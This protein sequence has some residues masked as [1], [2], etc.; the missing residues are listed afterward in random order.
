MRGHRNSR[1]R[2]A[3]GICTAE[4]MD[5]HGSVSTSVARVGVVV[6]CAADGSRPVGGEQ[7]TK[8]YFFSTLTPRGVGLGGAVT[9]TR[10]NCVKTPQHHTSHCLLV[11]SAVYG[12]LNRRTRIARVQ[13]LADQS[14]HPAP[15]HF[16][17]SR[18]ILVQVVSATP[19]HV[20]IGRRVGTDL[21]RLGHV[22]ATVE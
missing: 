6:V 2:C 22:Q 11:A 4:A 19:P 5:F 1:R 8:V 9:D 12:T 17:P 3:C 7:R 16:Q 14:T 13:M 10:Q 21:A 20:Q 15:A 18:F